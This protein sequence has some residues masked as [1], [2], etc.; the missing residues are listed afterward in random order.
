MKFRKGKG[1]HVRSVWRKVGEWGGSGKGGWGATH[2]AIGKVARSGNANTVP[3][4]RMGR[5][6]VLNK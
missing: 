4:S 5:E 3:G 6:C 1:Q 2:P